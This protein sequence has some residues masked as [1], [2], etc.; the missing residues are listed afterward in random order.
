[1]DG[2]REGLLHEGPLPGREPVRLRGPCGRQGRE[3][4]P[5]AGGGQ[6]AGLG[7]QQFAGGR[8]GPRHRDVHRDHR[9]GLRPPRRRAELRAVPL[10]HRGAAAGALAEERRAAEHYGESRPGRGLHPGAGRQDEDRCGGVVAGPDGHRGRAGEVREQLGQV[11]PEAVRGLLAGAQRVPDRGGKAEGAAHAEVDPA[12]VQ[13]LEGGGLLGDHEGLVVG[14][15]DPAGAD[16]E[17][18]G[19]G[20]QGGHQHRRRGPGDPG[21]RV[22]LGHPEPVVAQ[23]LR[24]LGPLQDAG[25]VLGLRGAVPGVGAVEE[26]E[27]DVGE[28][29]GAHNPGGAGSIPG[30]CRRPVRPGADHGAVR[31]PEGAAVPGAGDA[32]AVDRPLLERAAQGEGPAGTAP[33]PEPGGERGRVERQGHAVG[34]CVHQA[35]APVGALG[36]GPVVEPGRRRGD[37]GGQP[38]GHEHVGGAGRAGAAG[39]V[40]HRGH[41]PRAGRDKDVLVCEDRWR[42]EPFSRRGRGPPRRRPSR[43]WRT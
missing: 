39:Q 5:G 27:R 9:V 10:E 23:L 26:G 34:G 15:H 20:G 1:V 7:Q 28:G 30:R 32:A 40:L 29:H 31:E 36:V 17:A 3:L 18:A 11:V 4:A 21:H 19:P 6:G 14:E 8:A 43:A 41:G 42:R 12:G 13:G 38:R 37:G 2:G 35:D 16:P 25:E 24:A 22:V 33:A